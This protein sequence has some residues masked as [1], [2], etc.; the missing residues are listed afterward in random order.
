MAPP[1]L[2]LLATTRTRPDSRAHASHVWWWRHRGFNFKIWSITLLF[3][4]SLNV[5]WLCYYP[6]DVSHL[7]QAWGGV[8]PNK[9]SKNPHIR[10][11]LIWQMS[12]CDTSWCHTWWWWCQS[13]AVQG[14]ADTRSRVGGLSVRSQECQWNGSP[15]DH[16]Q[17]LYIF[18]VFW[19][20]DCIFVCMCV[21]KTWL[22]CKCKGSMSFYNVSS[23][24]KTFNSI[25]GWHWEYP[26]LK[27][28]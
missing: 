16:E 11:S 3:I 22:C 2:R 26:W 1:P 15:L 5:P 18:L 13:E 24:W 4:S 9:D 28:D 20:Q 12:Y 6:P 14:S 19:Y 17:H 25:P 8:K 7:Q 21:S 23:C 27:L 10:S